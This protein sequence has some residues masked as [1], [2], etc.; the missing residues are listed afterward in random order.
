[1]TTVLVVD[2]SVVA[3]KVAGGYVE[4]HDLE[5]LHAKNGREALEVIERE[6]PDIV[7]TDLMMPEMDGLELVKRIRLDYSR[8]PVILMTAHGSEETAVNALNAGASSYVPKQNLE[9]GL[10]DALNIVL[11][12]LEATRER[13]KVRKL[14]EHS[15]SRFVLGYETDA[16]RALISYLQDALVQLSFC[17]ETAIFQLSTALA[18]A[19]T[20]AIDHGN[21][22]LDSKLRE[23]SGGAYFKQRQQRMA[24][25]GRGS[26][27]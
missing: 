20:N 9:S 16:P 14:L 27:W 21:L 8:V 12:T 13:E 22:E 11:A 4:S 5:A 17:D 3:R 2:D 26:G 7:L 10:D 25:Q 1:M 24:E 6:H 19:I 18:E 15:E 23:D